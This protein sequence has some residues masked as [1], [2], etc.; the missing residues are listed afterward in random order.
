ML[1]VSSVCVNLTLMDHLAKETGGV[2]K[3][4]KEQNLTRYFTG[5]PCSRDHVAQRNTQS[6]ECMACHAL[7]RTVGLAPREKFT[8]TVWARRKSRNPEGLRLGHAKRA[9]KRY[10]ANPEKQR[11]YSR[12][13]RGLPEPTRPCP[14]VCECCGRLPGRRALALDHDHVTGTFRG[15][16]CGRCNTA[17][18]SLGDTLAAAQNA[19]RYLQRAP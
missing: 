16:L 17:L 1:T 15:W 9:K 4:A 5:V 13:S 6:G 2:R 8:S 12:K 10:A 11:I 7:R 19:V 14:D 3:A 18:G